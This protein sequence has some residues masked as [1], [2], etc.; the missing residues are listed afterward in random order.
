MLYGEYHER[1]MSGAAG[2]TRWETEEEG[3]ERREGE[4]A[5][6][7]EAARRAVRA[8]V[9][10]PGIKDVPYLHVYAPNGTPK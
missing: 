10:G 8:G 9:D 5:G 1:Y 6:E 3:D 2:S 7:E 4:V